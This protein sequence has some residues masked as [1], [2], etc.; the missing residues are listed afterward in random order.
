MA[1][2]TFTHSFNFSDS[3]TRE[4]VYQINED[5][6][7]VLATFRDTISTTGTIAEVHR[8]FSQL[9]DQYTAPT[10]MMSSDPA[11]ESEASRLIKMI[12]TNLAS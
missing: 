12:E 10:R 4:S 5:I 7:Q 3:E 1:N 11:I 2:L 9:F 6:T 8:S